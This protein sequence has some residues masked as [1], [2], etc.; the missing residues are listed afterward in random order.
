MVIAVNLGVK[1][2]TTNESYDEKE[3]P[4]YLKRG[5][6]SGFRGRGRSNGRGGC[7]GQSSNNRGKGQ[8]QSTLQSKNENS[9]GGNFKGGCLYNQTYL[10]YDVSLTSKLN[11]LETGAYITKTENR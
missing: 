4:D 2:G 3:Y 10:H 5:R 8:A 9:S 7:R 1:C 11:S 6:A